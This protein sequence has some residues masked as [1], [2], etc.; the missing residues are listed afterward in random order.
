MEKEL[1]A[2]KMGVPDEVRIGR[3]GHLYDYDEFMRYYGG[4]PTGRLRWIEAA[5][6]EPSR[7]AL[8]KWVTNKRIESQSAVRYACSF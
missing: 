2:A 3:N 5:S 7:S 4:W 1:C 8:A 6:M